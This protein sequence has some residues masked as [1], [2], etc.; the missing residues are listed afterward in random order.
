MRR[1]LSWWSAG[2]PP[3]KGAAAI[4]DAWAK[5]M[6]DTAL[7]LV[8]APDTVTVAK[9][10]EIAYTQGAYTLTFTDP[11]RHKPVE[12]KGAYVTYAKGDDGKWHAVVDY[13][14]ETPAAK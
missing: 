4:P 11:N 12:A 5:M 8:F 2:S 10:G 14:T 9:S 7:S 1:T 3:V 6:T 13:A